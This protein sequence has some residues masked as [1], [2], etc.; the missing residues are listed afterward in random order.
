MH[1]V[2]KRLDTDNVIVRCQRR[3]VETYSARAFWCAFRCVI[4][5]VV[6]HLEVKE[7]PFRSLAT[8]VMPSVNPGGKL[9]SVD[10]PA[11]TGPAVQSV[12]V[13]VTA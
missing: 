8:A 3:H 13:K 12:V 7:A 6:G 5:V 2:V 11:E 1:E 4:E 10:E 9:V